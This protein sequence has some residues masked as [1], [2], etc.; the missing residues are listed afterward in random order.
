MWLVT[1]SR[2]LPVVAL[3]GRYPTNKLMGREAVPDRQD[4][5]SSPMRREEDIRY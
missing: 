1:L 5:F 3:V 4:L 2:Q